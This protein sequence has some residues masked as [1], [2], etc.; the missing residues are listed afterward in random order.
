MTDCQLLICPGHTGLN[1]RYVQGC[2]N[3]YSIGTRTVANN[4]GD[5]HVE[6]GCFCPKCGT[7]L[8]PTALE[9]EHTRGAA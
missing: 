4:Y 5:E 2:G 8:L 9:I 7:R 6:H 1:G 3:V